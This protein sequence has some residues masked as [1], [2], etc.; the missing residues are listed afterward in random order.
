M[1]QA[2]SPPVDVFPVAQAVHEADPVTE[3][4]LSAQLVQSPPEAEYCP[5]PQFAQAV[6]VPAATY[7]PAAHAV[8]AEDPVEAA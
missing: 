5:A 4:L 2:A 8:H 7:L 6:F 1:T 3:Y